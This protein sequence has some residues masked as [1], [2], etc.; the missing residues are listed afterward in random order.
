MVDEIPPYYGTIASGRAR[1]PRPALE[2]ELDSLLER[3]NGAR[4][5][6]LRRIGKSTEARACIDRLKQRKKEWVFIELDAQGC[7]SEARLVQDFL[8]AL[9]SKNLADRITQAVT[10][11]GMIAKGAREALQKFAGPQADIQ[12]YFGPIMTAIE[13][14]LSSKDGLVLVIDEL[15]W[16]CR[17]ILESDD[18]QGRIRVEVLLAALRRWRDRGVRMLLLGSI[19]MAA[20]GRRYGLDRNHLNDLLPHDI[21]PLEPEEARTM[22]AAMVAGSQATGWSDGHTAQFLD[23]CEA[24]YPAI[25]QEAFIRLT[26]GGIAIALA[27]LSDIFAERIRPDI[28]AIFFGQFD[29]RLQRYR[30]LPAPLPQLVPALLTAVLTAPAQSI[31]YPALVAAAGN[32]DAAD[33]SDALLMLREDGFLMARSPRHGP[34]Q[35]RAA[36][37]LVSCWWAQRRPGGA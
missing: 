29:Q 32:V 4:L 31:E 28:D 33:L 27:R 35:W 21:P 16:L 11:D 23:E 25:L 9:P 10:G 5:F 3:S 6:G 15:P 12:A 37:G 7:A 30:E 13:R 24:F 34:Q 22:V 18:T 14:S 19:G 20:L 2:A 26:P 36:S 1:F 17:S 8:S